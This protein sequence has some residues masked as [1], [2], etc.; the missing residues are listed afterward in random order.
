MKVTTNVPNC[1]TPYLLTTSPSHIPPNSS[2]AAKSNWFSIVLPPHDRITSHFRETLD[3][4]TIT[5]CSPHNIPGAVD[6]VI[7]CFRSIDEVEN[8]YARKIT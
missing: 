6:Q 4:D 5:S 8:V 2:C 7:R 3:F 1:A